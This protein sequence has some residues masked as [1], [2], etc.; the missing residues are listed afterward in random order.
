MSRK[1]PQK[2]KQSQKRFEFI[3]K[4]RRRPRGRAATKAGTSNAKNRS[5][6]RLQDSFGGLPFDRDYK[7]EPNLRLCIINPLTPTPSETATMIEQGLPSPQQAASALEPLAKIIDDKTAK[8]RD[9]L[10]AMQMLKRCLLE[11]ERL[12]QSQD[13]APDIK[14]DIIDALR[15]YRRS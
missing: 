3:D 11:L 8:A 7:S 5:L 12:L 1:I 4:N 2:P 9:R 6:S 10:N 14:K 15:K 13:T